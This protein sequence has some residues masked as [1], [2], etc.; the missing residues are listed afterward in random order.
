M[1]DML[2]PSVPRIIGELLRYL[3]A[4]PGFGSL[5]D[6]PRYQAMVAAAKARLATAEN[7]V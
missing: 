7:T 4:D 5:H 1:L 6:H 3:Q 2:E